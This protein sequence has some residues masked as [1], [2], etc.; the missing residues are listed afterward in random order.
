[1]INS[2]SYFWYTINLAF[3]LVCHKLDLSALPFHCVLLGQ[4]MEG[5]G[6][7][8]G[9]CAVLALQK[10]DL[11]CASGFFVALCMRHIVLRY[12]SVVPH[13][14]VLHLGG[15]ARAGGNLCT[16]WRQV[17]VCNYYKRAGLRLIISSGHNI[18][19][20]FRDHHHS[21]VRQLAHN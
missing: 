18:N 8:G 20:Q 7:G 14:A 9:C 11:H 2:T 1:M 4:C 17:E 3:D 19:T 16:G 6:T 15:A 21:T 10:V 13:T 5:I 12:V